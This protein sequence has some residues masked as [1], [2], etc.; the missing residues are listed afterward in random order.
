MKRFTKAFYALALVAVL[1]VC[2]VQ[3][4]NDPWVKNKIASFTPSSG[5]EAF[6]MQFA[7][8]FCAKDAAAMYADFGPDFAAQGTEADLATSL[9]NIP[10]NCRGV[11]YMGVVHG[12][13]GT[14]YF[15]V[16]DLGGTEEWWGITVVDGKVVGIE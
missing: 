13:K 3:V 12:D 5:D 7:T 6:V 1:V 4:A 15:I 11:R 10:W 2:G 9:N 14:E 16:M 8:A